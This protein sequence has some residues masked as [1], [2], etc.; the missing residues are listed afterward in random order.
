VGLEAET[1]L[2]SLSNK[3]AVTSTQLIAQWTLPDRLRGKPDATVSIRAPSLPALA[4][5]TSVQL[6]SARTARVEVT[7]QIARAGT[8]IVVRVFDAFDNPGPGAKLVA[9]ASGMPGEF[10][11]GTMGTYQATYAP[12][13]NLGVGF[14]EVEVR[15]TESGITGR[16]SIA[17][18]A[19]S[20]P[21]TTWVRVG[22]ITNFGRLQSPVVAGG[23]AGRLPVASFALSLG[24][25]GGYHAGRST[26]LEVGTGEAVS[27][28]LTA[29]PVM[30]RAAIEKPIGPFVPYVGLASGAILSRAEVSSRTTGK[31][32][33]GATGFGICGLAGASTFLGPGRVG[34]EVGYLHAVVAH[35]AMT[36]NLGGLQVSAAYHIDL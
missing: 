1:D 20:R 26:S 19:F 35:A 6:R 23:V 4:A 3:S 15:D 33:R 22:Y 28:S 2:G 29:V 27:S 14:D 5:K 8:G 32:V 9:R 25:E 30:G 18:R 7:T 11:E 34:L 24:V 16:T 10:L 13:S 36:G 12:P 21:L 17:L 31:I